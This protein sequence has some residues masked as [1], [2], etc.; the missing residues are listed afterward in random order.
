[1]KPIIENEWGRKE[2]KNKTKKTFTDKIAKSLRFYGVDFL[3]KHTV[4]NYTW[5]DRKEL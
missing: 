2:K 3:F 5:N 1:M 4:T